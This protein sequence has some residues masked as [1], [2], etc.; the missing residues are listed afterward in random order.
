LLN[1]RHLRAF[2]A[3]AE[4]GS[5][6][7]SSQALRRA[8]SAV[9]RAIQELERALGAE[10]F[11]RHTHGMMLTDVGRALQLRVER[12]QAEMSAASAAFANDLADARC[13]HNAPIFTFSIGRQRLLT[14][15]ELAEQHSI[16]AVSESLGVSQPAVS[17]TLREIEDS[18]GVSLFRRTA[19]GVMPTPLGAVL[20]LHVR[21]SLNELRIA[22][23]EI[24][25]LKD[26]GR[27]SV[28]VGSL[29]VGRARLLPDAITTL[30]ARFP[31]LSVTTEEGTFEHLAARLRAGAIDFILGALRP[32]EQTLGFT[33]KIIAHDT[34]SA[35][36]RSGHPLLRRRRISAEDLRAVR[37]VL[38]P[39]GA[40]TRELVEASFAQRQLGRPHVKVETA[41][42][43]VTFGIVMQSD[44]VTAVSKH[45]F[46]LDLVA[47][48]LQ[49]LPVELSRTRR[50]IGILQREGGIPSQA[51]RR[52]IEILLSRGEADRASNESATFKSATRRAR[53]N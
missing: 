33:R 43:A 53:R 7:K 51:A 45:Q 4:T 44:M 6:T 2:S 15:V 46:H 26:A 21:R 5:I 35:V 12:A 13:V 11:E 10:L 34:M 38:P 52:L 29:S 19:R 32:L 48:G 50:P 14:Y 23:D 30:L 42:L 49:V 41:D 40:P 22:E 1:P 37:W 36:V 16:S 31:N 27:G 25:V 3:V 47:A 17:Q 28:T 39:L 18:V 24:S 8:Q 20:A 9:T